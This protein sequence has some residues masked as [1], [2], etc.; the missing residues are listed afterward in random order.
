[1]GRGLVIGFL[2]GAV[3]A[4]VLF[5]LLDRRDP[6]PEP[7]RAAE[8]AAGP[9]A[10]APAGGPSET[11]SLRK[12]LAGAQAEIEEL[13]RKSAAPGEAKPP[14]ADAAEE[15]SWPS[16]AARFRAIV[17]KLGRIP[18]DEGPESQELGL[19]IVALVRKLARE[20][21]IPP[22]E[23]IASPDGWP[24]LAAALLEGQDP[25]LDAEGRRLLE[26]TLA[27]NRAA[28]EALAAKRG[29]MLGVERA[30]EIERIGD[31]FTRALRHGLP[32]PAAEAVDGLE[33]IWDENLPEYG[34]AYSG[35]G[36]RS[37]EDI[38]RIWTEDWGRVLQLREDQRM[39]LGPILDAYQ[40]EAEAIQK[41][42]DA[43]KAS[44]QRADWAAW[45]NRSLDGMIAAQRKILEQLDLDEGQ[46]EALRGWN[47]VY[48]THI[49]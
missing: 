3:T 4:A 45:R 23:M 17:K 12:A 36:A 7:A 26:A 47:T 30:R 11:E 46:V 1:M 27:E 19:D 49:Q 21:G 8:A 31:G 33:D 35:W 15:P 6:S 10:A 37:S 5:K 44:G 20:K 41:E 40:R 13:K 43:A 29:E 14:G 28:W 9:G 18:A 2:L 39:K 24:A 48:E 32:D 38:R 34:P 25:P 16:V 22:A 42:R